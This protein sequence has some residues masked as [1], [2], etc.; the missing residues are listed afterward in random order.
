MT[1]VFIHLAIRRRSVTILL[2]AIIIALMASAYG[3]ATAPIAAKKE[4]QH[5]R[6]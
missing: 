5:E 2:L 4:N 3:G 6:Q 1:S